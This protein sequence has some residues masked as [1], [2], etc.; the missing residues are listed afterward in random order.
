MNNIASST[1]KFKNYV[2]FLK[3]LNICELHNKAKIFEDDN[4]IRYLYGYREI[5]GIQFIVLNSEWDFFGKA[6]KQAEG[7]L[8]LGADLVADAL[9]DIEDSGNSLKPIIAIFHRPIIP[10][11]HISERNYY[12]NNLENVDNRL[13]SSA[14]IIL[15][16]HVHIGKFANYGKRA[17]SFSCGTLHSVDV[18]VPEYWLFEFKNNTYKARKYKWNLPNKRNRNG[19]W[20][21]DPNDDYSEFVWTLGQINPLDTEE[22]HFEILMDLIKSYNEQTINRAEAIIK[23][24]EKLP[25]ALQDIA[26]RL[27]DQA[28]ANASDKNVTANNSLAKGFEKELLLGDKIDFSENSKEDKTKHE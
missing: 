18:E 5:K 25:I 1:Y 7:C 10:N 11:I 24:Q 19:I 23:I 17:W 27:F 26:S 12:K 8:R 21:Q 4:S 15:N 13:N 6:D 28:I 20:I 22:Q 14:D 16:G 3:D 9:E 2:Q